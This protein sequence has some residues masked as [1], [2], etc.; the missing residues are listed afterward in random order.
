MENLTLKF[1]IINNDDFL[2]SW[3]IILL[4]TYLNINLLRKLYIHI[5]IPMDMKSS[6]DWNKSPHSRQYNGK[7][8]S[9]IWHN[10]FSS[11]TFSFA[12]SH[13]RI[14]NISEAHK[15]QSAFTLGCTLSTW[16][17]RHFEQQ[18]IFLQNRQTLLVC[19]SWKIFENGYAAL[20]MNTLSFSISELDCQNDRMFTNRTAQ[21]QTRLSVRPWRNNKRAYTHSCTYIKVEVYEN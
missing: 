11:S 17:S 8:F 20:L 6:L 5:Y 14:G 15:E 9:T 19:S 18:N 21:R 16:R 2:F 12:N 1:S 7:C 3:V 13:C 10:N 4:L